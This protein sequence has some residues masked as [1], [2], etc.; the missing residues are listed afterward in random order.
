[1]KTNEPIKI[2]FEFMPTKAGGLIPAG[3]KEKLQITCIDGMA[4]LKFKDPIFTRRLKELD[5][6]GKYLEQTQT[7]VSYYPN[8]TKQQV[9]NHLGSLLRKLK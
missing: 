5:K 3:V 7:F 4:I 1:M 2:V 8:F 6:E 9:A